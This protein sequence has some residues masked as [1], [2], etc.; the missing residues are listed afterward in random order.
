M[1]WIL[2]NRG[3]CGLSKEF[4]STGVI[5]VCILYLHFIYNKEKTEEIIDGFLKDAKLINRS[6]WIKINAILIEMV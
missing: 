5:R 2:C 4:L 1:T 3:Q 6:S